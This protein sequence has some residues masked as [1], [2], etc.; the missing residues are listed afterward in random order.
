[1]KDFAVLNYLIMWEKRMLH[2]SVSRKIISLLFV[3]FTFVLVIAADDSEWYW[4]QPITRIE[5]IG[6][7][8]IKKSE[9]SGI[10]SS[11]M[12]QPFTYD[13]YN[14]IL[15]TFYALDYFE[16]IN[17]YTNHDS[18]NNN[19]VC[20]VFELVERP[21]IS[22][23]VFS[24]NKKIRNGELREQIKIKASDIYVES[25]VLIDERVLRNYYLQ[26]GYTTARVSHSVE[27]THDG[28]VVT[29]NIDEGSNTV[30]TEISFVG[31]TIASERTLKNKLELK[32]VGLFRNGAYQPATLEKDKQKVIAYYREHGYADASLLDVKIDYE[33]NEEK[34]RTELKITFIVQEGQQYTYGGL[35]ISG[36]EVFSSE[37]LLRVPRLKTGAIY[38]ETKFQ[39]D[40]ATIQSVYYENGYMSNEFYPVSKKD[41]DRHEISYE[42]AVREHARSHIENIIVKGNTK[43]K[44]KVI[45]REIP[46]EAG[47]IFSRDKVINGLRNLMNLQYF[48]SVIPEPQPG[49]EE[50]LVDLVWSVEEQSTSTIQLGVTFSGVTD[51]NTIPIS[52]FFKLENSNL[53]GEGKVIS[54][55][56]TLSN[57]EQSLDFGYS[58]NWIGNMP[59]GF[60]QNLSLSHIN[61]TGLV[62][63][64]TP[65]MSLSQK[66]YY[67]NYDSW[68]ISLSQGL[69]R[70][71]YPDYAILSAAAVLGNSFTNNFYDES[72]YVPVDLTL[73]ATA[74]KWA[75]SNYAYTSFSVDNRD[76]S[77]DPTKGWFASQ[78]L[79][80]YGL[81]PKLEKEFYLR[82]D[83]KLEGYFKLLDIKFTENYNFKL[84]LAGYSG[85]SLLLPTNGN[86][87]SES[88]KLYI[89]GMFNGRGWTNTYKNAKGQLM[90]SNKLE[91]RA[92]LVP[93]V[94][95]V[96]AFIDAVA[97][98]EGYNDFFS[99][100]M[101]DYY[102]SYGPGIRFLIPQF[103]LHFLFAWKFRVQDGNPK[104]DDNPF[105]FVLS[106]NVI[107]R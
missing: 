19:N 82:S 51:P 85:L 8:N 78:R 50:N 83:T 62:N 91:L 74:N 105:Q 10:T 13:L 75:I 97:V 32:E 45:L 96:D 40:L 69:S 77:Y 49:S 93:G 39:E 42:L 1:M 18:K 37:E 107:N 46:I 55:S 34:Q 24:G 98:K 65:D 60:S 25:A 79:T 54:A 102:F 22:S 33:T 4:D 20:L 36:N 15:D 41:A 61:A 38:N 59:L 52:L 64:W 58:Q 44:E 68:V 92:P 101:N 9:L 21:V 14:E 26:K 3:F 17:A 63:Y 71:W 53:L 100:T 6:L 29:F 30:I 12:N 5:F 87:I 80:W 2:K 88:N 67:M 23:I 31:N 94:I 76:L 57:T 70:R 27:E 35:T 103:P 47:D 11:Y 86:A 7:K 104:L 73:A 28:M 106:F 56:T 72:L 66:Y 89:D 95:G 90:F 84:V 48:S 99:I 16:D 81:I 43:T